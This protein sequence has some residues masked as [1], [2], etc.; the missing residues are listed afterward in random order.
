[1]RYTRENSAVRLSSVA[2]T[3][4]TRL[5]SIN[6]CK[7]ARSRKIRRLRKDFTKRDGRVSAYNDSVTLRNANPFPHG[8][9]SGSRPAHAKGI[10]YE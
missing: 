6:H 5:T 10:I 7:L 1:M 3:N 4:L 2:G 9:Y 8:G